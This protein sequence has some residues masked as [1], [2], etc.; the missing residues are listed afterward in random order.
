MK[1]VF[2]G[3]MQLTDWTHHTRHRKVHVWYEV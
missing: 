3:N 1:H 2:L